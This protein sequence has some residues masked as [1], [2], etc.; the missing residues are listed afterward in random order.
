M[1]GCLR[2]VG[3]R[4][5]STTTST[6]SN[7]ADLDTNDVLGHHLVLRAG[8]Y[9]PPGVCQHRRCI[10]NS[11]GAAPTPPTSTPSPGVAMPCGGTLCR[12]DSHPHLLPAHLALRNK[13]NRDWR[14]VD[15]ILRPCTPLKT[16]RL[17][18]SSAHAHVAWGDRPTMAE[19]SGRLAMGVRGTIMRVCLDGMLVL[20]PIG[21]RQGFMCG[22]TCAC[23][24]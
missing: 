6:Q 14:C 1:R 19:G 2:P 3:R 13:S 5:E 23:A 24:L 12:T 16:L 21:S 7:A 10:G 22:G 8:A 4:G 11:E 17:S 18:A 9:Y 15:T 20:E